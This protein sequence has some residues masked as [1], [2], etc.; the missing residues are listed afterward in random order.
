MVDE[1]LVPAKPSASVTGQ[2]LRRFL[3][4]ADRASNR[5]VARRERNAHGC[6]SA[7]CDVEKTQDESRGQHD[8]NACTAAAPR[9]T[10]PWPVPAPLVAHAHPLLGQLSASWGGKLESVGVLSAEY[11]APLGLLVV[12]AV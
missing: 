8:D 2:D 11:V 5:Q 1:I 6:A 9:A 4:R 12:V 7:N 10:P 3:F